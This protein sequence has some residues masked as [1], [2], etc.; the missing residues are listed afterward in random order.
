MAKHHSEDY[1]L[2]AVKY[3][4]KIDNQVKTCE[5]FKCS[6][7]SLMRWVDKYKKSGEIKRETY[8]K[9]FEGSYKREVKYVPRKST[10]SKKL[11]IYK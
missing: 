7:R 3:Y 11:K 9:L 8:K 1:K 2:S 6:E 4:L 10:H 5:I